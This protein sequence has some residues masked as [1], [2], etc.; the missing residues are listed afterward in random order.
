VLRSTSGLR[1]GLPAA[2][3]NRGDR[4]T[5]VAIFSGPSSRAESSAR[6]FG[7][8]KEGRSYTLS[9]RSV[10]DAPFSGYRSENVISEADAAMYR[11]KAGKK[12]KR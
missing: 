12:L 8:G 6:H 10:R 1:Y 4:P 5:S 2:A 7:D 9:A 3:T 11:E